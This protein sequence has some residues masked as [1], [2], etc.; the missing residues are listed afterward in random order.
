MAKLK[1]IWSLFDGSGFM[2]RKWAE[3]GHTCYCFNYDGEDHGT[4]EMRVNH[5]NI[6]YINTWIY[7]GFYPND[8]VAGIPSPDIIFAFPP[9]T[10]MAQS[11]AKHER[12]TE[13]VAQA[14]ELA[15]VAE[16]LG[17]HYNCPWMVENPVGKLSTQWR[18]PDAYF[19]PYQYGDYMDGSEESMHPRMPA[20]DGY[21]KKTCIWHGNGFIMPEKRPGPINIGLFWGWKYLGGDSPKTKQL[22]SLTPRGFANAVYLAN[23]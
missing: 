20:F 15:K 8:V 10:L 4:Y 1:V 19:D 5:P 16:V 9:C 13:G 11:G 6:H 17:N 12:V 7:P 22:R 18:K 21:T 3:A 14:V 2:V 23:R